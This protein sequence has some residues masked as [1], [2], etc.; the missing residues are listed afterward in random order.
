MAWRWGIC[1]IT[2][3]RPLIFNYC[4]KIL[5]LSIDVLAI[6]DAE[7]FGSGAVEENQTPRPT[8]VHDFF[9]AFQRRPLEMYIN[10]VLEKVT[11]KLS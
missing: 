6:F 4:Y 8:F 7:H 10:E 2:G 5:E 9:I 1:V 11:G 3:S